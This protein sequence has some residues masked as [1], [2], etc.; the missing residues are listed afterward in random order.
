MPWLQIRRGGND[1]VSPGRRG[2]H[3]QANLEFGQEGASGFACVEKLATWIRMNV[4]SNIVEPR[5]LRVINVS[6][7]NSLAKCHV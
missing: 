2:F 7:R 4:H 6:N 5:A 3:G 1:G